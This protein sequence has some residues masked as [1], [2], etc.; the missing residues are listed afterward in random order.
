MTHK[1]VL[2]NGLLFLR[3][4]FFIILNLGISDGIQ[5]LIQTLM[6]YELYINN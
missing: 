4:V 5:S 2:V 1:S 6:Y 3:K